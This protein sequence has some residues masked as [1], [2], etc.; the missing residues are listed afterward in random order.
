MT[1]RHGTDLALQLQ[2]Y[3]LT[4]A[5]I[6]YRL[7]DYPQF[8]QTYIWQDYDMPPYLPHLHRFLFF[9]QNNLEGK[10][11][12]VR[13][14]SLSGIQEPLFYHGDTEFTLH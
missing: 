1:T 9:W 8:L 13:V 4:T 6:L 2:G 5:E 3:T 10:L 12:Q 7:P 14:M 11:Y